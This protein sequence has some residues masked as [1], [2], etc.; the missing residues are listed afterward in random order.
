MGLKDYAIAMLYTIILIVSVVYCWYKFEGK[1]IRFKN[2]KLYA[3]IISATVI[4]AFNFLIINKYI[5]IILITIILMLIYK[6]LF[7]ETIQ[8]CVLTPIYSQV[9]IFFAELIYLAVVLGVMHGFDEQTMNTI[10]AQFI[11]NIS[12]SAIL[13][14]FMQ[15]KFVHK[16]YNLLLKLTDRI[17]TRQLIVFCLI[18]M[19]ILNILIMGS[20]YKIQFEYFILINASVYSI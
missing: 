2:Y 18:G 4:T 6:F 10:F 9:L 1:K 15:F 17:R 14:I 11:T 16:V 19:L 7:N 13:I 20:Y 12:V 8:K 5:R 3:T